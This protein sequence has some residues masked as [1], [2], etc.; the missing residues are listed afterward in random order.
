MNLHNGTV[1]DIA[2][3]PASPAY[4]TLMERLG[5]AP[6]PPPLGRLAKW[7]RWY[8]KKRG[9]P[10]TADVGTLANLFTALKDAT[11]EA[12]GGGGGGGQPI[13]RVAVS[14]PSIP[15]L[16]PEDLTDALEHADLRNWL[17]RDTP[18]DYP[19]K[20]V[21]QSRAVFAGNGHGLCGTYTD[22]LYCEF[23]D[24]DL[25]RRL[26]L[27]VSLTRHALYAS[28]D[29]V[30]SAFPRWMSDGPRVLDFEAGLE[31]GRGRFASD[32]DY[33]AHVRAQIV[34]LVR[35]NAKRPLEVVLL[36][37]ENATHGAFLATLRDALAELSP[38]SVEPPNVDTAAVADPAFA[39]ARGM[40]VFARRRQEVPGHCKEL[41]K[42]EKQR[43]AE[44][45]G[46]R[47]GRAELR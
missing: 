27:F 22:H 19:P 9:R 7:Q 6:P 28:L 26:A 46:E 36:G 16:T 47:E 12:L 41:P 5:N 39:A 42:C 2:Q 44:R 25:P 17:D 34:G 29:V 14:L 24:S 15:A 3:T 38:V 37:G 45:A 33:W 30:G 10:A 43:K 20:H 8:N 1:L 31:H 23:E 13:Y 32:A 35:G 4:K 18:R 40:A 21:A 11:E